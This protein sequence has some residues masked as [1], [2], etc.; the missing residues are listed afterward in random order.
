MIYLVNAIDNWTNCANSAQTWLVF[1]KT[2]FNKYK[3]SKVRHFIIVQNYHVQLDNNDVGKR[4][5]WNMSQWINFLFV[6]IFDRKPTVLSVY[7]TPVRLFGEGPWYAG[8]WAV[9]YKR[10]LTRQNPQLWHKVSSSHVVRQYSIEEAAPCSSILITWSHTMC[11]HVYHS[12][13]NGSK[14]MLN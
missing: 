12:M 4:W 14:L 11:S 10:G 7:R 9:H 13:S 3:L 5:A 8:H 2:V 1:N 6:Y